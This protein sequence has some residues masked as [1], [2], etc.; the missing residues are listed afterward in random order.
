MDAF[1]KIYATILSDEVTFFFCTVMLIWLSLALFKL[2]RPSRTS[3]AGA[4]FVA[5][6]PNGLVTLGVLGTFTGILIGLLDFDVARIDDSVP[7]LLAGL[8]IAFTT[9]IVGIAAAILFRLVRVLSPGEVASG[10]V[11]PDDIHAA[12][13]EI[14]DDARSSSERASDQLH[15]LR[16]AISADGDSSLLT[17]VQKLRASVQ[18]GQSEMIREFR[19]FAKHMV[20]NNQ[21]ALIEALQEVIRDFNQNLT[22]QFG[23]NFKQLNEAVHSLVAWQDKYRE[24]VDALEDRL[25]VAV[26]AIE[27][28]QA[29]LESVQTHAE[30]IPEAI[31]PLEPVLAGINTQTEV[32]GAHTET[33]AALRDKALEAFP[34]IEANLEKLTTGLATSID[35]AVASSR[36]ALEEGEQAHSELRQRYDAFLEDTGQARQRFEE[37]LANALKQMSEQSSQAF[38]QHWALIEASAA[39][40]QKTISES[41]AKSVD[42]INEQFTTFDEQMQDE[43]RR[44]LELLGK[45]LASVSEKLVADYTPLTQRLQELVNLGRSAH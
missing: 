29:A 32:L 39:E 27:A 1:A 6:T 11:T 34:T 43:L 21:K 16:N 33:L 20:E 5:M 7:Q 18:D 37:E 38:V 2:F 3:R 4:R 9:S 10:G 30:R 26:E 25:D 12:L 28:S 23:E 24:H 17:Q 42:T 45:N 15:E 41:W 35:Q 36:R 13:L 8:K 14:R 44:A 22:E 31:K 19:E 40:A